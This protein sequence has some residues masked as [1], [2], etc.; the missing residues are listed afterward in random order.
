MKEGQKREKE[1]GH[2]VREGHEGGRRKG[3]RNVKIGKAK[4]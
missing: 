4:M 3:K 2:R 1:E